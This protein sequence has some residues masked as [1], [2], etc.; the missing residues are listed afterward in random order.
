MNMHHM[1]YILTMHQRIKFEQR[2]DNGGT[3]I[4]NVFE[5]KDGKLTKLYSR[6]EAYYRENLLKLKNDEEEIL[7]M[8]PLK[9]VLP[10][11]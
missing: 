1:T 4:A 5:L 10:G 9:K 7:L 6:G 11:H 3:V 8:E 2:V